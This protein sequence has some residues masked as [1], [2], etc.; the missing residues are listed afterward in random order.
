MDSR[1]HPSA[2]ETEG[3]PANPASTAAQRRPNYQ[4]NS[5]KWP[6]CWT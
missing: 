2:R 5:A 4:L 1:K 3:T 6:H